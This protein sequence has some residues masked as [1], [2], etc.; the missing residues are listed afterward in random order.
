MSYNSKPVP[1]AADSTVTIIGAKICGFVPTAAGTWT[2]TLRYGDGAPDL[3]LPGIAVPAG[4]VGLF[5]KLPI[6]VGTVARSSIT[7]SGGGAGIL[8]MA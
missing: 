5:H 7:T 6:F 1:V 3:V 2:F 4:N 8:C